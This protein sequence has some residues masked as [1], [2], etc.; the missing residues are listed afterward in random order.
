MRRPAHRAIRYK[1]IF[2][3]IVIKAYETRSLAPIVD[4]LP[5]S[6]RTY[7]EVMAQSVDNRRIAKTKDIAIALGKTQGQAGKARHELLKKGIVVA[8][9]RGELMFNIP[10]LREFVLKDAPQNPEPILAQEWGF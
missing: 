9:A 7:L 5:L 1:R 2:R 8:I 6:E 4:A 3:Y 10:Y